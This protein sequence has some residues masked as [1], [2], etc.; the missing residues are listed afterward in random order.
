MTQ[1]SIDAIRKAIAAG[2]PVNV[3][4]RFPLAL[5]DGSVMFGCSIG[6]GKDAT[7]WVARV[8]YEAARCP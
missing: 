8:L 2:E 3:T 7:W 4:E 1:E 5:D 6:K